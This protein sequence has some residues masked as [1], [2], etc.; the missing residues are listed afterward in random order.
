MDNTEWLI[1][2][3][4]ADSHSRAHGWTKA[5]QGTE[6]KMLDIWTWKRLTSSSCQR[7]SMKWNRQ[8]MRWNV[9]AMTVTGCFWHT[10]NMLARRELKVSENGQLAEWRRDTNR[11]Y[12]HQS[13]RRS[14]CRSHTAS[15]RGR[16]G[17]FYTGTGTAHMSFQLRT[18]SIAMTTDQRPPTDHLMD[19]GLC[20]YLRSANHSKHSV[21]CGKCKEGT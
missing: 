21:N 5:W 20:C 19:F 6:P 9:L 13:C 16:S 14:R 10:V 15:G 1:P 18:T 4:L 12:L 8:Q 7:D 2:S 3:L 11:I 17:C